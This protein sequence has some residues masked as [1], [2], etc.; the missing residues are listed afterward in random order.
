M[1][2]RVR[3]GSEMSSQLPEVPPPPPHRSLS[4]THTA[5]LPSLVASLHAC[6]SG[7]SLKPLLLFMNVKMLSLKSGRLNGKC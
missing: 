7:R 6:P 2:E 1:T 5:T 3:I 4:H